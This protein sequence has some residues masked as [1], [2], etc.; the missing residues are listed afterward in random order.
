[1]WKRISKKEIH[2]FGFF[3]KVESHVVRSPKGNIISDWAYLNSPDWVSVVPVNKYG[4]I[5]CFSQQKYAIK[6]QSLAFPGGYIE[7]GESA[8]NCAKRELREE[9]GLKARRWIKLGEYTVDSNRGMG[10]GYFFL[11]L[12]AKEGPGKR[13]IDQETLDK[14]HAL[15]VPRA[16]KLLKSNKF[17][18]LA[19]SAA[20]GLA[21]NHLANEEYNPFQKF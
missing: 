11:A 18:L 9:A 1:M 17:K 7:K 14:P 21:L 16:R 12:D 3:L 13:D 4:E 15:S 2:D 6:G 10:T 20:L 19:W 5:V 8:L